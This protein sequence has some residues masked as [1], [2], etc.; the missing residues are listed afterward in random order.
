MKLKNSYKKLIIK[1]KIYLSANFICDIYLI[2]FLMMCK[3]FNY[4]N[5]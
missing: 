2:I 4:L 1:E 3:I 5:M